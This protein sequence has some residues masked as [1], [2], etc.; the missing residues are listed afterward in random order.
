MAKRT[1]QRKYA[2]SRD[3][4][5]DRISFLFYGDIL[6]ENDGQKCIFN[7]GCNNLGG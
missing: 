7:A 2:G 3:Y 1:E 4:P 5:A 6:L